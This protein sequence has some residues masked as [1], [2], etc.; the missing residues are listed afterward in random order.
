MDSIRNESRDLEQGNPSDSKVCK[1]VTLH[2]PLANVTYSETT[3][4]QN[5]TAAYQNIDD[6]DEDR[7]SFLSLE[8]KKHSVHS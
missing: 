4:K 7:V 5:P 3:R 1:T 6:G 8:D 2:Y